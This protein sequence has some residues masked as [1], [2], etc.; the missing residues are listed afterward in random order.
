MIV[1]ELEKLS[2]MGFDWNR[3]DQEERAKKV[4]K[5]KPG[6][7]KTRTKNRAANKKA[8]AQRRKNR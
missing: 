6:T 8:R 7:V 3:F 2:G 1:N 4:V 5:N